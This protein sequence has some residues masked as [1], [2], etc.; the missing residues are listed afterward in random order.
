MAPSTDLSVP[1]QNKG[2]HYKS[3]KRLFAKWHGAVASSK[4]VA[5]V[6]INWDIEP[7]K[8]YRE[9]LATSWMTKTDLWRANESFTTFCVRT[10]ISR[11]VLKRFMEKKSVA[12]RVSNVAE[13]QAYPK[14][15]CTIS[16]KVCSIHVN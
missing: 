13:R 11:S 7:H 10:G 6:R 15:S 4:Q 5:T 2:K 9:R 3:R 8:A 16:A 14:P 12:K 1:K